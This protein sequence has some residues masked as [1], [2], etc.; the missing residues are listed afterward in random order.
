[1]Y[2]QNTLSGYDG[3]ADMWGFGADPEPK[4]AP[5]PPTLTPTPPAPV[6]TPTPAPKLIPK[7]IPKLLPKLLPTL[8]PTPIPTTETIA[9]TGSAKTILPIP[10]SYGQG[11]FNPYGPGT[12]YGDRGPYGP[13]PLRAETLRS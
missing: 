11:H 5:T 7:I 10:V 9:P 6:P 8:T 3:L 2:I 12:P 13:R 1:M 4:I